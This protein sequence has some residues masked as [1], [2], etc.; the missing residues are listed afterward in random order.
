MQLIS[1]IVGSRDWSELSSDNEAEIRV[2]F[3]VMKENIEQPIIGLNVIELMVKNTEGKVDRDKLL[4]RMMKCFHQ[5]RDSDIQALISIICATNSPF[6]S[7][8]KPLY[9]SEAWCTTIQMK[10]TLIY[11]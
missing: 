4:G 11:M 7:C 8:L 3:L 9:Q 10:M 6:P 2:P 1:H 5:S